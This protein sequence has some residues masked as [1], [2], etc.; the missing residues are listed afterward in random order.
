MYLNFKQKLN[1]VAF[2]AGDS[3]RLASVKIRCLDIASFLGCDMLLNAKD[4]QM[5]GSDYNIFICVKPSFNVEELDVLRKR[6]TVVWDVLDHDPPLGHVDVLITSTE[7]AK[8][9]LNTSTPVVV[10]PHHHCNIEG[11]DCDPKANC[12]SWIGHKQWLPNGIENELSVRLVDG[13]N[14]EQVSNFYEESTICVNTRAKNSQTELHLSLN[15]GIKLINCIGFGI[16][17][18]SDS[19]PAYRE[20][21][22]YC[23]LFTN[24]G[25]YT[26]LLEKLKT[27]PSLYNELRDNC[28][29][30][31][32]TYHIKT[33]C[34]RYRD[35]INSI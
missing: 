16:P 24:N 2:L 21:D 31:S 8:D 4:P 29:A 35:L 18:I 32:D 22:K 5:V 15:S 27:S 9:V 34:K 10:I 26:E 13:C 20:I 30:L 1:R 12:V 25:E 6:G 33:I 23:T 3:N 28:L 11:I 7:Y 19:E 17:S 14:R